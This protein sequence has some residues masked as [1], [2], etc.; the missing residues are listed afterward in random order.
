MVAT[1]TA[2]FPRVLAFAVGTPQDRSCWQNIVLAACAASEE[3]RLTSLDPDISAMLARRLDVPAPTAYPALTDD[4][5]P[6][7]RYII[8]AW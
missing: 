6:V 3:V 4:Y 2:V 7:D 1:Y 5:A 8:S